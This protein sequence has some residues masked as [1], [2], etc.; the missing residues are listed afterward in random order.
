MKNHLHLYKYPTQRESISP[1]SPSDQKSYVT[2]RSNPARNKE[3]S[4]RMKPRSNT[5]KQDLLGYPV[6]PDISSLGGDEGVE[7]GQEDDCCVMNMLV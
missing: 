2:G 5:E 4:P 7:L 1:H 3:N 6:R